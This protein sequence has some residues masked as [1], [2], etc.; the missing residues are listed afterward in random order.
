MTK[1]HST[2]HSKPKAVEIRFF[3]DAKRD[4]S[5]VIRV[6][7][8]AVTRPAAILRFSDVISACTVGSSYSFGTGS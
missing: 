8:V 7:A 4:A 2:P 1:R 6:H 3:I 5:I